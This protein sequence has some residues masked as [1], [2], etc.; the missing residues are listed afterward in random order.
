[1][2][3]QAYKF[4]VVNEDDRTK[5]NYKQFVKSLRWFDKQQQLGQLQNYDID[6]VVKF[7]GY[8]NPQIQYGEGGIEKQ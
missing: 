8:F 5:Y 3:Y 6:N 4:K 2:Q 1:M 7:N